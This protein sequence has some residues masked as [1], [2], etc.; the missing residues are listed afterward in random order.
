MKKDFK[1]KKLSFRKLKISD[2]NQFKNLF[3]SCFKKKISLDFYK[4]RYFSD[5]FSC[6]YGIFISS[7]LIANVGL[8]SL[9]INN[10]KNENIFSRHSS[11][12]LRSYRGNKVYSDLLKKVKQKILTDVRLIAMWPNKNNFSN[13]GIKQNKIF[14][15]KYYLYKNFSKKNCLYETKNSSIEELSKLKEFLNFKK[16]FFFKN[17]NYLKK[18]YLKYKKKEYF[19]NRLELNNQVSFFIIKKNKDNSGLNYIILEHFG[20]EKL[21][22]KHLEYLIKSQKNLIF[23]SDKKINKPDTKLINKLNFKIGILKGVELKRFK[24][25]FIKK[26]IFLGDTDIFISTK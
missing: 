22:S 2:Y 5:K 15:K 13:F 11:M 16:N 17:F 24:N 12:V 8:F 21:K 4:W 25:F 14:T 18:R 9:K 23:L 6:C 26:E 20:S 19:I 3:F 1:N 10:Q 7:K